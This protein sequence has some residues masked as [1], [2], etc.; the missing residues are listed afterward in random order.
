[1]VS[2]MFRIQGC[3]FKNGNSKKTNQPYEMAEVTAI[4]LGANPCLKTPLVF[5]L[6]KVDM[7]MHTDL[8]GRV[9]E[10]AILSVGVYNGKLDFK[11]RISRKSWEAS[12]A[13]QPK[14][15]PTRPPAPAPPAPAPL[16]QPARV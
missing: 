3:E 11:A 5:N 14:E 13:A 12:K 15:M 2:G 1:M 6:E 9:V 10:V 7:D 4:D 16:G 8:E